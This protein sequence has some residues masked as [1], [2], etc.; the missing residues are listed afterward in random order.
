MLRL[1]APLAFGGIKEGEKMATP[2]VYVICDKNCKFEGMTKEQI[3]AAIM[4]AVETGE[5]RDVDAGFVSK[6]KTIDGKYIQFFL[7]DQYEYE[8][9]SEEQ[10]KDNLF[11]VITNE[12]TKNGLLQFLHELSEA[13]EALLESKPETDRAVEKLGIFC[14]ENN[15]LT[16]KNQFS[17]VF[18]S[19][20]V[21]GWYGIRFKDYKTI[22]P[23]LIYLKSPK[24]ITD[25]AEEFISTEFYS[26]NAFRFYNLNG[27]W[28]GELG[29]FNGDTWEKEELGILDSCEL[30]LLFAD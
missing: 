27:A 11:A 6:V 10:K 26:G 7:D 18:S 14:D 5:I 23:A 28:V 20:L 15:N 16:C 19:D 1:F 4:Q 24:E 12:T 25:T 30:K 17:G 21:S 13:V 29:K 9:L 8:A 22:N 2:K 3:H